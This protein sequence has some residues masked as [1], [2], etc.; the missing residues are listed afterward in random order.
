MDRNISWWKISSNLLSS[1]IKQISPWLLHSLTFLIGS[2]C[3]L[4]IFLFFNYCSHYWEHSCFI[5]S[6]SMTQLL[7][8]G[9]TFSCHTKLTTILIMIS[10]PCLLRMI[11][12]VYFFMIIASFSIGLLHHIKYTRDQELTLQAH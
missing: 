4:S 6:R 12:F 2:L 1:K 9:S 8:F 5:K 11:F 3:F 10:V 7:N